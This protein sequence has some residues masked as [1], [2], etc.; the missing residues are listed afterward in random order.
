MRISIKKVLITLTFLLFINYL[1]KGQVWQKFYG[2]AE[3]DVIN[4][5]CNT[6]DGGFIA[7]GA[8]LSFKTGTLDG[9]NPDIYIIKIDA[10]GTVVWEKNFGGFKNEN[11]GLIIET[12][13]GGYLIGGQTTSFGDQDLGDMYVLKIDALGDLE[14]SKTYGSAKI[15]GTR[16][17]VETKDENFLI[18]GQ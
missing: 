11:A 16:S 6:S 8:S 4:A 17:I 2:G 5:T 9:F 13:D 10:C 1:S 12:S 14:W 7:M 18:M 3:L 15:E